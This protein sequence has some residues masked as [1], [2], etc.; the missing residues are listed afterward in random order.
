MS[1]KIDTPK[2][3]NSSTTSNKK[4]SGFTAEETRGDE[5]ARKRAESGG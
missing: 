3:A 1:E 2:T 4:T 5:R